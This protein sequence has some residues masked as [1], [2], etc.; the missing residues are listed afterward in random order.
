MT[1]SHLRMDRERRTLEAMIR[2]YCQ[3]R[4]GTGNGLCP[5]WSLLTAYAAG[6]LERCP[7]QEGKTTCAKCPVH[8]YK[9]DMR[10]E[11]R[12]VQ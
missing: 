9:P 5:R 2:I 7:F 12:A 1:N 6:R 8:C 3:G 10:Q 11:I 4:H